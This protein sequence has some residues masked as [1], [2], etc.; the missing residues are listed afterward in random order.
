MPAEYIE[1]DFANLPAC[2]EISLS[3]G[4][5]LIANGPVGGPFTPSCMQY[6][7]SNATTFPLEIF[8]FTNTAWTQLTP[9]TGSV[10]NATQLVDLCVD[11]PANLLAGGRY[12]ATG[13]MKNILTANLQTRQVVLSVGPPSVVSSPS[14][15]HTSTN[16]PVSLS[17]GWVDGGNTDSYDVYFGTSSP[18]PFVSN[19]LLLNHNPGALNQA[20]Q[21]FWRIDARN[22]NGVTTGPT[23]SFTTQ[24]VSNIAD[25]YLY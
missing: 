7:F 13:S 5:N 17:L 23:W 10:T 12:Q 15:A 6:S 8:G 18:P 24:I 19:T 14:P 25:W 22:A 3:P 20:T 1:T 9:T 4:T 2:P 16:Q 11:G 21:Y